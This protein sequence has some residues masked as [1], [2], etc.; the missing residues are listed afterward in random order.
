MEILLQFLNKLGYSDTETG[1]KMKQR[2]QISE[3]LW[4]VFE[5]L[6]IPDTGVL[7]QQKNSYQLGNSSII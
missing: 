1:A 3:K 4:S 7:K 6:Q 5:L 2:C